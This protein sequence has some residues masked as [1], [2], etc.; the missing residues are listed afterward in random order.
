MFKRMSGTIF[1]DL[2]PLYTT[3]RIEVKEDGDAAPLPLIIWIP[4]IEANQTEQVCEEQHRKKESIG[5]RPIS[6]TSSA[7][8]RLTKPGKQRVTIRTTTGY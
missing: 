8:W 7:L 2:R 3:R 6:L 1:G 4:V 5:L